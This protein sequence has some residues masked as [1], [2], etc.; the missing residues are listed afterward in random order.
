MDSRGDQSGCSGD[1]SVASGCPATRILARFCG[2]REDV[3]AQV[4]PGRKLDRH[5]VREPMPR[6]SVHDRRGDEFSDAE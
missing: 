5:V 1:E 6:R 4:E 2:A 3:D